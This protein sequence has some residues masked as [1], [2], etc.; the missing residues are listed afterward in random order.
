M[1]LT[2]DCLDLSSRSLRSGFDKTMLKAILSVSKSVFPH[3]GR[4]QSIR[5][6]RRT[7]HKEY[8]TASI[9]IGAVLFLIIKFPKTEN[10]KQSALVK[11]EPERGINLS[12]FFTADAYASPFY[13]HFLPLLNDRAMI[14]RAKTRTA[15]GSTAP[16][17]GLTTSR[18]IPLMTKFNR[19][20]NSRVTSPSPKKTPRVMPARRG[21][22][23]RNRIHA[24]GTHPFC[25]DARLVMFPL[26][27]CAQH[28]A[29]PPAY[30]EYPSLFL[31]TALRRV[32]D[33]DSCGARQQ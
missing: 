6:R 24:I 23:A 28:A 3:P 9:F 27:H 17:I 18:I 21:V 4:H 30:T 25:R 2:Q 33:E 8:K 10:Q 12:G 26:E 20:G 31:A 1:S 16:R 22:P 5:G 32:R 11:Q 19:F 15:I 7:S 29:F 14:P 13:D